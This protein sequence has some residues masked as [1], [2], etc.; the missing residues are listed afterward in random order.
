MA[1]FR[2]PHLVR[3]IVHTADGNF[4]IERG[5]AEMPD[6]VGTSLGW[7]RVDEEPSSVTTTPRLVSRAADGTADHRA[8]P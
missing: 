7:T 8:T 4:L 5:V 1:L 3:G 6:E 2:H